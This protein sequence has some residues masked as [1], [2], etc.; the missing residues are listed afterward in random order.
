M[1]IVLAVL[2]ALLF[3]QTVHS[4]AQ[5][6]SNYEAGISALNNHDYDLAFDLLLP[7][8]EAGNSDAQS[9]IA[10]MY[11]WGE[12]R[13]P[14]YAEHFRWS[15]RSAEA[16]NPTGQFDVATDYYSGRGVAQDIKAGLKWTTLAAEG[17]DDYAQLALGIRYLNGLGVSLDLE[18]GKHYLAQ[19]AE[20]NEPRALMLTASAHIFGEFGF[21]ADFDKGIGFLKRAAE[22]HHAGAQ[23]S[24]GMH[25]LNK[26]QSEAELSEGLK[27]LT[28]SA[29]VGCEKAISAL[30]PLRA[31]VSDSVAERATELAD[32]WLVAQPARA[33]HDHR[34]YKQAFCSTAP[35][36]NALTATRG[37]DGSEAVLHAHTQNGPL[38]L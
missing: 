32:Q 4:T 26:A 33:P 5:D 12:G 7:L 8:A 14:D 16:G 35:I 1:R 36:V 22:H 28:L 2:S 24:Y 11:Y 6:L 10:H 23:L 25:L 27:W 3:V 15:L 18:R 19:A 21:A 30:V 37:E 34:D 20:Q 9:K 17:G 31:N 13:A 29:M 38:P